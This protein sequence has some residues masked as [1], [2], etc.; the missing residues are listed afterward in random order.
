MYMTAALLAL[1]L[2]SR[3]GVYALV[4]ECTADALICIA[5]PAVRFGDHAACEQHIEDIKHTPPRLPLVMGKCVSWSPP[6]NWRDGQ[7]E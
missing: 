3:V 4:V 5:H 2:A 7:W 6:W 1:A